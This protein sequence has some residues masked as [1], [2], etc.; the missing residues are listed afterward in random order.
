[1]NILIIT[2]FS[3]AQGYE[4][5]LPR[6]QTNFR[7]VIRWDR[8]QD[9]EL[10]TGNRKITVKMGDFIDFICPVRSLDKENRIGRRQL[11]SRPK[12]LTLYQLS[13]VDS[14]RNCNETVGTFIFNCRNQLE[15]FEQEDKLTMKVQQRSASLL[16]FTFKPNTTYYYLS[17]SDLPK[18]NRALHRLKRNKNLMDRNFPENCFK[19]KYSLRMSIFVEPDPS[20][21]YTQTANAELTFILICVTTIRPKISE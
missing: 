20:C 19:N 15:A 12:N 4:K 7:H 1:M 8:E 5:R 21:K 13:D 9:P 14:Y 3:I 2:F 11:A 18:S 16:G 17:K 10:E 6:Q